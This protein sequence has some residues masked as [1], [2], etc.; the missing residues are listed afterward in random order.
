MR[1][2]TKLLLLMAV[3]GRR[4]ES[5]SASDTTSSSSSSRD[6]TRPHSTIR[7]DN[8]VSS[9]RTVFRHT[10]AAALVAAATTASVSPKTANAAC[11]Q[12]DLRPVCIGIYKIPDE[13]IYPFFRTPE[14][15]K[16]YWPDLAYVPRIE[17][18]K[19]FE[20]AMVL[21][22][23]QRTLASEIQQQVLLEGDLEEAGIGV[24][25]LLP[26]IGNGCNAV[27]QDLAE[28]NIRVSGGMVKGGDSE[29]LSPVFRDLERQIMDVN[30]YWG[31]ADLVIGQG[32]R[33]E[34]GASSTIVRI[35]VLQSLRDATRALDEFLATAKRLSLAKKDGSLV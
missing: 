19:S 27:L 14:E 18:P 4:A 28:T 24:L 7:K 8:V 25:G 2:P 15:F 21:L 16:T 3:V 6:H 22:Q 5:W 13:E 34:L 11:L 33:G 20:S 9:R 32:L 10:A 23:T 1:L 35:R 12:G 30:Y 29:T 26:K 31:D 17:K